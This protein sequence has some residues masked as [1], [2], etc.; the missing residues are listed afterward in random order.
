MKKNFCKGVISLVLT[1]IVCLSGHAQYKALKVGD[2]VPE[3][4]WTETFNMINC[5]SQSLS[6]NNDRDKLLLIDFWATWCGSCLRNYPKLEE[7]QKKF[8]NQIK[9]LSVTTQ[10]K[11]E[12]QKF[13]SSKNGQRYKNLCSKV[14][15]VTFVKYFPHFAIPFIVWIKDGILI[16]TT[17]AEQVTEKTI[18]EVLSNEKS[19]LQTVVQID[20]KKPLMLSENFELEREAKL[21]TYNMLVKGRIRAIPFGSGFHTDGDVVYGRQLTN[22][23]LLNIY[24][25]IAYQLFE[26]VGEKFSNKRVINLAQTRDQI[27]FDTSLDNK[28]NASKWYSIEYIVPSSQSQYLYGQ[29][30]KYV[31]ENTAYTASIEKRLTKCLVLKRTSFNDKIATKGG[32]ELANFLSNPSITRNVILDY[33]IADLNADDKITPL[34]VVDETS[35]TG[36]VDL[37]LSNFKDLQSLQKE[38]AKYDLALIEEVRNLPMLVVK[39]KLQN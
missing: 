2:K 34:P 5:D 35:Y 39:D 28:E 11:T 33:M 4:F 30:L 13:L 3:A 22:Y 7:L 26:Q 21:L 36:K 14:E 19:S 37:I 10:K 25:T 8:G 20:R 12:V 27:E 18:A 16:N 15:D 23:S 38:L 9:V 29:M 6:L 32:V 31:N 24:T 17:D 1:I